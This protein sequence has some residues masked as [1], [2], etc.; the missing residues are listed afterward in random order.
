MVTEHYTVAGHTRQLLRQSDTSVASHITANFCFEASYWLEGGKH[1]LYFSV[2]LTIAMSLVAMLY[3]WRKPSI[4]NTSTASVYN[5]IIE[6]DSQK[7]RQRSSLPVGG[8]T[9]MLHK[10]CSGNG[11]LKKRFWKDI[12]FGTVVVWWGV[13]RVII[14][15]FPNYC[16]HIPI[17]CISLSKVSLFILFFKTSWRYTNL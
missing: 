2:L 15:F 17:I 16:I 5:R 13:H 1:F 12:H 7:E 14:Y 8:R 4:A 9:S 3:N 11:D 6:W 10:I